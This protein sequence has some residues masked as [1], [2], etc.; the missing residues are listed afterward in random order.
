MTYLIINR[1]KHLNNKFVLSTRYYKQ[2]RFRRVATIAIGLVIS[3]AI[4]SVHRA[5]KDCLPLQLRF[6][7]LYPPGT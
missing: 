3:F 2:F 7:V 6:D 5:I 4:H 1:F